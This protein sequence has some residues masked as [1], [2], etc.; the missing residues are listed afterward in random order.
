M[1]IPLG[2]CFSSLLRLPSFI[3]IKKSCLAISSNAIA[4]FS[5]V[6]DDVSNRK[7]RLYNF[8]IFSA[9]SYF[10]YLFSTKSKCV[11]INTSIVFDGAY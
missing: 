4:T 10:T 7:S 6:L 2:I 11:P 1:G 3:M 8:I 5:A 9:S